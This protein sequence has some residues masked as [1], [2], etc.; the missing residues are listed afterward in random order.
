MNSDTY[1]ATTSTSTSACPWTVLQTYHGRKRLRQQVTCNDVSFV[2][3]GTRRDKRGGKQM[4]RTKSKR[5][6][7]THPSQATRDVKQSPKLGKG[8][9]GQAYILETHDGRPIVAGLLK[10]YERDCLGSMQ[11]PAFWVNAGARIAELL[12]HTLVEPRHSPHIIAPWFTCAGHGVAQG[13]QHKGTHSAVQISERAKYGTL[14][15]YARQWIATMW[16]KQ[17]RQRVNAPSQSDFD[18]TLMARVLLFQVVYTLDV[19]QQFFPRFRHN[20]LRD[21]NVFI[22]VGPPPGTTTSYIGRGR[23]WRVPNIGAVALIADYDLATIPGLVDNYLTI[24]YTFSMPQIM[25]GTRQNHGADLFVFISHFIDV[26]G[27]HVDPSLTRALYQLWPALQKQPD[28]PSC[29]RVPDTDSRTFPTPRDILT[30]SGLFDVFINHTPLENRRQHVE[31]YGV[32][33]HVAPVTTL[34]EAVRNATAQCGPKQKHATGDTCTT[35]ATTTATTTRTTPLPRVPV[36]RPNPPNSNSNS[37]SDFGFGQSCI[38]H[39]MA[40]HDTTTL[41]DRLDQLWHLQDWG[42]PHVRASDVDTTGKI[43]VDAA[44]VLGKRYL[45]SH[46]VPD[47]TTWWPAIFALAYRDTLHKHGLRRPEG[48]KRGCAWILDHYAEWW[49]NWQDDV[50][51]NDW[52]TYGESNVRTCATQLLHVAQQWTWWQQHE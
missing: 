43:I 4:R 50:P 8:A 28:A 46:Q 13:H 21:E 5:D 44:I 18:S 27:A 40:T 12:W 38:T 14:K 6:L 45:H 15:D 26:V 22:Q 36:F 32:Q 16:R 39:D 7:Q 47:N 37:N 49:L 23:A 33:E 3:P 29:K 11:S 51:L 24:E 35:A 10:P 25:Y 30:R 41:V 48:N 19:I 42:P 31:S 17:R 20:D 52:K 9:F 2:V 34:P 1:M